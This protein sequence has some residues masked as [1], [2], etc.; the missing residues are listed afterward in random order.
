MLTLAW[1][2]WLALLPLPWLAR[3]LL[4]PAPAPQ[5]AALALPD[6]A[7]LPAGSTGARRSGLSIRGLLALCA[8]ALLVSAVA[9]PQWLGEPQGIP[10]TGRDLML[11]MDLSGSM[12]ERDFRGEDGWVDRLTAIKMVA[13]DFIDRRTGDRIG[14]ILFGENAYVQAPLTFDHETVKLL[15]DESF[16]GLPGRR[17]AIGDSIG[18]AI[19]TLTGTE[20]EGHGEQSVLVL[21]TD[22]AQTAGELE[23][24]Q[25]AELAARRGLRIHTIGVGTDRSGEGSGDEGEFGIRPGGRGSTD[26]D[27]PTLIRIAELTGGEYFRARSTEELEGIYAALDELEPVETEEPG[28]RPVAELYPWPL[29]G[30]LLFAAAAALWGQRPWPRRGDADAG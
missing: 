7:L 8:W 6:P 29:G 19:R 17:T 9:R 2:W 3:R 10:A 1:W 24:V 13:N 30:A 22:G 5:Q 11:A 20:R 16:I 21:L 23:P 26:L 15:L 14:L 4:P 27:E 12:A 28:Y 18:L 25:A